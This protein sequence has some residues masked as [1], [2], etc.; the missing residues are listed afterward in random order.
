MPRSRPLP[1]PA[2][3][4]PALARALGG[5]PLIGGDDRAGYEALL[6]SVT[7]TV[8][9]VDPLEQAWVRDVVD[10]IWEALRLRRLKAALMTVTAHHGMRMALVAVYPEL[11]V[12]ELARGW[13]AR[14]LAATARADAILEAAGLGIDHVMAHTLSLHI[15]KIERIDRM[16]AS[17]EA[18]RAATLHEIA[19]YRRELA[20]SLRGAAEAAIAE[21]EFEVVEAKEMPAAA[22]AAEG[23]REPPADAAA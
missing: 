10:L 18:R 2:V 23:S 9:P 14:D 19:G 12:F 4:L 15:D 17:A 21:A 20:A 3:P 6:D 11:D 7:A 16:V 22:P 8:A 13:A 5:A 1:T